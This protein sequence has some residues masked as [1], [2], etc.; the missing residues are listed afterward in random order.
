MKPA[1]L[2]WLRMDTI[3][4]THEVTKKYGDFLAV[5]HISF[6]V[7]RGEI[8]AFLGP[9]GAGKTTTIKMLTTLLH[10]TGGHIEIDGHNPMTHQ[11][12]VRRTF[13]IVFQDPSLDDELTAQENMHFHA[14]LYSVDPSIRAK[15][16]IPMV[17]RTDPTIPGSL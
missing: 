9:N 4:K 5:D 7:H 11:E 15:R 12:E 14:V 6:E 10:P 2:V 17:T 1:M 16:T 3:M 8:F 13:G